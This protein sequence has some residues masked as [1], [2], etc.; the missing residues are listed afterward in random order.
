[1]L[2]LDSLTVRIEEFERGQSAT[3]GITTLKANLVRLCRDMDKLNSTDFSMF[4]G[5]V[6]IPDVS[7]VNILACFD[8]PPPTTIRDEIRYDDD[9]ADFEVE[10]NDEQLGKREETM[11]EDL[12]DLEGAMF[13][14]AR[15]SLL[16]DT[17]MIGSSGAKDVEIHGT[18]A[19]TDGV[20]DMQT[21]PQA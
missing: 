8:V 13:E 14:T 15:Q 7:S 6:E 17:S 18:D 19:P 16:R 2:A 4:F 10:T 20:T 21:S 3:Y 12:A 11:Y 9:D 1:M 5:T